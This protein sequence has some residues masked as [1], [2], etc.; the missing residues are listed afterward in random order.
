MKLRRSLAALT[1]AALLAISNPALA[2]GFEED[3]EAIQALR[4]A[5]VDLSQ[6]IWLEFIFHFED[7]QGAQKMWNALAGDDFRGQIRPGQNASGYMLFA[8]KRMLV[9]EAGLARL[10][11]RLDR[12][13]AEYKGT[14]EGWGAP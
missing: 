2:A 10:R 12:L 9:E 7:A 14:Y 3:L 5:G 8:R 13:A 4:E 11:E 6:P 1:A